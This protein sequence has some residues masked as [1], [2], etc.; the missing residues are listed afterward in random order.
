MTNDNV[1]TFDYLTGL[2]AMERIADGETVDQA[3]RNALAVKAKCDADPW[4]LAPGRAVT[5]RLVAEAYRAAA[6]VRGV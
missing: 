2:E 6:R 5:D 1:T 4:H 3:I